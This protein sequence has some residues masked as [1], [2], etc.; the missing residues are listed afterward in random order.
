M[1]IRASLVCL[2]AFGLTTVVSAADQDKIQGKWKVE[3]VVKNGKPQDEAKEM[4]LTFEGNK[5]KMTRDGQEREMGFK[6]DESKSPKWMTVDIM[7]KAGDGIYSLEGDTLKVCHGEG[8][9]APRPTEFVTK[10]GSNTVVLT[11]KRVK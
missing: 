1:L 9:N 8:D 6:L 4:V 7:G 3:S 10:E 5:I 2:C 11:L